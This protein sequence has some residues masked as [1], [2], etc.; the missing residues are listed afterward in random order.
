MG[1]DSDPLFGSGWGFGSR[2]LKKKGK[3][4]KKLNEHPWNRFG[5]ANRVGLEWGAT[6]GLPGFRVS[7]LGIRA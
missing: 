2:H 1:F 3:K 6:M 4:K 7:Q 5:S